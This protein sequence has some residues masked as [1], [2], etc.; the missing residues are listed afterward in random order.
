VIHPDEAVRLIDGLDCRLGAERL[1]LASALGR[2]PAKEIV[3]LL[4]QP[5]FDKAT[6]DGFAYATADGA[7]AG[8]GASFAVVDAIAA[9][10]PPPAPLAAGECVR[11]MTGAPVPV[12]ACAVH[13]LER[14]EI[15]GARFSLAA[16]EDD[17]N[18]VRRGANRRAGD[19]LFPRR[20]LRPQDVALLASDGVAEIE[21]VSKPR[22]A[23]L[24]TGC[25]LR[26]P[27]EALPPGSIYDSNGPLLVAQAEA[28]GCE[29]SYAGIASDE[30][31]ALLE[32]VEAASSAADLLIVSG[33]VSA[34]DFD[35]VPAALERAG[36]ATLF[37]KIAMRPGMPALLCRRGSTFAYGMPG[38]PVSAFVNFEVIVKPLVW[39]FAGLSYVPAQARV[40]M[41]GRIHRDLADRVEFLPVELRGGLAFPLRYTGSTMLDALSRADALV[42]LEIDQREIP[43]GAKIFARLL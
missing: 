37:R 29:A 6:M 5:P 22:V 32:A 10:S 23:V 36:F 39:R 7:V 19:S 34:G 35:F 27:G 4:D 12:G 43:E 16:R 38:N 40:R 20:R 2:V 30:E 14:S 1:P 18:I 42:R 31:G 25:E 21:V 33:G 28:A 24:S 8:P 3:A 17:L 41:G 13:R 15:A 26:A 11:I 9:G